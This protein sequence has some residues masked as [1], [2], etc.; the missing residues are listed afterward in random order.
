MRAVGEHRDGVSAGLSIGGDLFAHRHLF[1]NEAG[2]WATALEL[3]DEEAV[4]MRVGLP[5]ERRK[6]RRTSGGLFAKRVDVMIAV[7][8]SDLDTFSGDDLIEYGSDRGHAA[9]R[10]RAGM[11]PRLRL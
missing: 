6:S 11:S 8:L 10:S 5:D 2:G 1:V 9:L 4:A 3:C 7:Q